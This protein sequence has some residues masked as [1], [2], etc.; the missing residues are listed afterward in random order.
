[1]LATVPREDVGHEGQST[2]RLDR[3]SA[4]GRNC[5]LGRY[6]LRLWSLCQNLHQG[7]RGLPSSDDLLSVTPGQRY[8]E[9]HQTKGEC[10]A[11]S[12]AV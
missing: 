10:W 3:S 12:P 5:S 11:F 6:H 1:M 4:E 7:H 8:A 9:G 2:E